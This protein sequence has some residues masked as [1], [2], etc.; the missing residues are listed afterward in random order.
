M[1]YIFKETVLSIICEKRDGNDNIIFKEE[2]S[3]N[4]LKVFGYNWVNVSSTFNKHD[5]RKHK[6][7][8]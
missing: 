7:K 6:F 5:R 4:I 3:I 1:P 2:E 8:F